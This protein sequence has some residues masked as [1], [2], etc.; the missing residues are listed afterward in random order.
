MPPTNPGERYLNGKEVNPYWPNV[1]FTH[2]LQDKDAV[3]L[4]DLWTG[5]S[6]HQ[7]SQLA[8]YSLGNN[9]NVLQYIWE[10][11]FQDF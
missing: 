2:G 11:A 4:K 5:F 1:I 6:P 8:R 3:D 7:A 9:V 10:E